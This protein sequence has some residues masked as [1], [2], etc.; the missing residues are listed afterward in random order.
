MHAEV[1]T[2]VT[3][4]EGILKRFELFVIVV[5]VTNGERTVRDPWGEVGG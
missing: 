5:K 2:I 4:N 3:V 1:D